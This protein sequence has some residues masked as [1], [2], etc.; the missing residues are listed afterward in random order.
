M[1]LEAF[2]IQALEAITLCVF[3]GMVAR[4]TEL[5]VF[6]L[7]VKYHDMSVATGMNGS[8]LFSFGNFPEVR[9]P[10]ILKFQRIHLGIGL[11]RSSAKIHCQWRHALAVRLIVIPFG[12]LQG[13]V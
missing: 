9:I 5:K 10:Y 3:V 7:M 4:D 12:T 11:R 1:T 8:V 6:L 13:R 2:K